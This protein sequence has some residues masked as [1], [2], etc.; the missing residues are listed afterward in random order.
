MERH[1]LVGHTDMLL[2]AGGSVQTQ[3]AIPNL[4]SAVGFVF[5]HQLVALEL[6]G[7]LQFTNISSTNAL[8]IT[9]GGF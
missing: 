5:Y 4:P 2:P 8:A 1:L 9:V 7:V 3:V 6:V